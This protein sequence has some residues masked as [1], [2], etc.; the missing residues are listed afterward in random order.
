[1]KDIVLAVVGPTASGKTSCAVEL[2]KRLNGEVICADSMQIYKEMQ[3]GTAAPTESEKSGIIHHLFNFITPDIKFNV[4]LY[5][6]KALNTIEKIISRNKLPV[7]AG[8]TGLY[9]NSITYNLD[10][11]KTSE[12]NELRDELSELYDNNPELVYNMLISIEPDSKD[13]IHINDK[14]RLIRR[15]EILKD[16]RV[17]DYNFNN[18]NDK[19]EFFIVGLTKER[20]KLYEDINKRVDVMFQCGLESEVR[21]VYNKYGSDITAFSAIGYKEFLP[22]FNKE[23]TIDNVSYSI[24]QNTRRFAKRQLTW[25]KRDKRIIWYNTDDYKNI[26]DLCNSIVFDFNNWR[27]NI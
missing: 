27:K 19:Y 11:T 23:E 13:R 25:F 10:F 2:C 24:K 15:L 6:D 3:I 12:D 7:L 21:E 26:N 20:S 18:Y 5:Q 9:V 16:G 1:M 17:G 14:K 8:G 4:S 22:Y